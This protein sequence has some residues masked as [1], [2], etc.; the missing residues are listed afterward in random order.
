MII[1]IGHDLTSIARVEH[2]LTGNANKRFLQRILTGV[3]LEYL[4]QHVGKQRAAEHVAGRFAAK[5]AVSKAF[6]C[7]I[8]GLLG[9]HDIEI[10]SHASGKPICSISNS[11]L[12]RL[13]LADQA[14]RVHLSITHELQLA[15]AYVIVEAC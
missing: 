13:Q 4:Q 8:G 14:I 9:F 1:G 15:S 3:E 12:E 11:A 7:G 5:E 6:G 10:V 2:I